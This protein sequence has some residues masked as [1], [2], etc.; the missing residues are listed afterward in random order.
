MALLLLRDSSLSGKGAR[1]INRIQAV[2]RCDSSRM[3]IVL[4]TD[5]HVIQQEVGKAGYRVRC[6][7]LLR[8]RARGEPQR[9]SDWDFY[10][11]TAPAASPKRAWEITDYICDRLVKEGMWAEISFPNEDAVATPAN[12]LVTLPVTSWK[13]S[14]ISMRRRPGCRS[15]KQGTIE[16]PTPSLSWRKTS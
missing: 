15:K 4:R 13:R 9:D 5:K 11:V 6:I 16:G 3:Q 14:G 12:T 2:L 7:F 8:S 10:V 1:W